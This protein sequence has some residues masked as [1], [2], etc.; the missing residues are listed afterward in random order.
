DHGNRSSVTGYGSSD[1]TR[2]KFTQ[3]ER[4]SESGLDYFL[5]RY[6]S[7]AQGRF[8]SVDPA[9]IGKGHLIKPQLLNR[10]E[11]AINNPLRFFD[12]DGQF[13]YDFHVRAFAPPKSFSGAGFRDDGRGFSADPNVTSRV[14]QSFTVDPTA[15]TFSGAKTA[16]D[17]SYWNGAKMTETPSGSAS[18]SFERN[19]L[20]NTI[21][22]I[23]SEF[24]GSNPFFAGLAPNIEVKS[25][26]AVTEDLKA[27]KL[28]VSMDL[29]SKQFPA[30]AALVADSS[31]QTIFLGG[32][33]AYG[34]A[35]NLIA[36]GQ[37]TVSS[38]D[39]V[40]GINNK[41]V[42]QSVTVD[43]KTHSVA[44]WNKLATA[45]SAGP[46]PREDKDKQR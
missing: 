3:K 44:D 14:K 7:S 12:P 34:N 22:V 32:G 29:S 6:Y 41:G 35:G 33:A 38:R 2:Q 9:G 40:I 39:F 4:D 45:N 8:T 24:K 15:R 25:S 20:G 30:T 10:Y 37:E 13:P 28:F 43:G 42:F 16:S 27:G 23:G 5:A 19:S 26:I 36:A 18:A 46:L 17:A 1:K 11:Y 31:G 21:A